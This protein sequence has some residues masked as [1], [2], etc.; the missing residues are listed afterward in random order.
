MKTTNER[1]LYPCGYHQDR[2]GTDDQKHAAAPIHRPRDRSTP[3][4]PRKRSRIQDMADLFQVSVP[5][6]SRHVIRADGPQAELIVQPPGIAHQ[7]GFDLQE[8]GRR[9]WLNSNPPRPPHRPAIQSKPTT[10]MRTTSPSMNSLKASAPRLM[11]ASWN[12][13]WWPLGALAWWAGRW[14]RGIFSRIIEGPDYSP[15]RSDDP[16]S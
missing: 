11:R 4:R 9:S 5:I 10:K 1:R 12:G 8:A 2:W 16:D 6:Q 14:G 3:H 15:E 13:R 7:L